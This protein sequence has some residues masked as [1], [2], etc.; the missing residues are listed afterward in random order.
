MTAVG[1]FETRWGGQ[2]MSVDWGKAEVELWG[3][4]DRL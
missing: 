1:T 3:R 4:Q 2:I